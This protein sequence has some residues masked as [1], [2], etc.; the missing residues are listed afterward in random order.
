M[1]R[2]ISVVLVLSVALVA[3]L[4]GCETPQQRE[5]IQ[6]LQRDV[7]S[8]DAEIQS[9][10]EQ[11]DALQNEVQTAKTG[12]ER[13]KKALME[14]GKKSEVAA[15]LSKEL[16]ELKAKEASE[17]A[18][19]TARQ[20]EIIELARTIPGARTISRPEGYMLVLAGGSLFKPG[21][22]ELR[23]EAKAALDRLGAYV[24]SHKEVTIRIDGH[25]DA[26]P[27]KR[28]PLP[29]GA[30]NHALS[31]GR[32]LAVFQYLNKTRKIDS[33]RMSVAGFGPNRPIVPVEKTDKDKERNRRVEVLFTFKD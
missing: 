16:D 28:T 23:K 24:S 2:S 27:I 11:I 14:A 30:S 15:D 8:R 10:N 5:R 7:E 6:A 29:W 26:T 19:R 3:V 21:S 4:P 13:L 33:K 20:K 17:E 12:S 31:T 32:A 25:S 1:L 9:L 22:V 18:R